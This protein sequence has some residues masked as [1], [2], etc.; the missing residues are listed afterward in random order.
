[1]CVF[2]PWSILPFDQV[3]Q[4]TRLYLGLAKFLRFRFLI[5]SLGCR[6]NQLLLILKLKSIGWSEKIFIEDRVKASEALWGLEFVCTSTNFTDY[7]ERSI[8]LMFKLLLG[9]IC[10]NIGGFQPD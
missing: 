3:L 9:P 2:E 7:F 8:L 10:E 1:M 4:C 6:S 5:C